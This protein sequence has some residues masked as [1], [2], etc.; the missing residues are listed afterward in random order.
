MSD[1]V[2]VM[3][4]GRIVEAGASQAVLGDPTHP[5]TRRLLAAVPRRGWKPSRNPA[6]EIIDNLQEE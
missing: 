3:K 2:V 5:Y 1:D 4:E 6:N